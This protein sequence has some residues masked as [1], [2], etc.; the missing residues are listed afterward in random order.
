MPTCTPRLNTRDKS[1]E[2]KPAS[3]MPAMEREISETERVAVDLVAERAP[4][5]VGAERA[6]MQPR[7][8]EALTAGS[9]ASH[10]RL[11]NACCMSGN[12]H[13]LAPRCRRW[14]NLRRPNTFGLYFHCLC[15]R[16]LFGSASNLADCGSAK[17]NGFKF[18]AFCVV[19][20]V[21]STL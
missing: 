2:P 1:V 13:R 14:M 21:R 4:A 19:W 6:Q 7:R 8:A 20:C 15:Q 16:L 18:T 17:R 10:Y 12:C 11:Q 3:L 9:R 5:V